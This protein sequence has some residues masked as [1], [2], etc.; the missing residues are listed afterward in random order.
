MKK[1]NWLETDISDIFSVFVLYFTL[2]VIISSL[3]VHLNE[4]IKD[5]RRNS[6]EQSR[7]NDLFVIKGTETKKIDFKNLISKFAAM[8]PRRKYFL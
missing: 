5:Y 6:M 4:L 2:P 8:K 7:L 3:E 1:Y